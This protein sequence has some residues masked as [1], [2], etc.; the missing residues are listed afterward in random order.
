VRSFQRNFR[1]QFKMTTQ[2]F[3]ALRRHREHP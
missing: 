3:R 1:R 2:A